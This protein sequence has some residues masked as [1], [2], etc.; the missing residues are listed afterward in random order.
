MAQAKM[1]IESLRTALNELGISID[2]N[3]EQAF[4]DAASSSTSSGKKVHAAIEAITQALGDVAIS[5]DEAARILNKMGA[6]NTISKTNEQ[7]KQ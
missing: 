7:L 3:L 2:Q 1:E 6:G 5:S 4:N